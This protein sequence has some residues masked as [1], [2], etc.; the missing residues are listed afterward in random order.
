MDQGTKTIDEE[1]HKASSNDETRMFRLIQMRHGLNLEMNGDP[2]GT[3]GNVSRMV[4]K[5][6]GIKNGSQKLIKEKLDEYFLS[7]VH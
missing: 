2:M 5:A 1:L 7:Q 4:S 3:G 6:L